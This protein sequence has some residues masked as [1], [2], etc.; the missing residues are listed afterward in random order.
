[1]EQPPQRPWG[2]RPPPPPPQPTPTPQQ[3]PWGYRPPPQPRA[4]RP[5]GAPPPWYRH[6]VGMLLIGAVVV[7][8][9]ALIVPSFTA[10]APEP[11]P[12]VTTANFGTPPTAVP[13]GATTTSAGR[14]ATA[15]D[16]LAQAAQA[17][18]RGAG[19]DVSVTA[20]PG[21]PV[22]VTWEI[23]RA[24]TQGLTENNARLGVMRIMRAF[25]QGELA[26]A[27][28]FREVR[29]V[30]RFQLPGQAVPTP[31]VRLRFTPQTV[32]R[33]EFDDRRYLEAFELADTAAV[34]PAFRG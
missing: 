33:T 6:P 3:R 10:D 32:A 28:G 8:L 18:L 34:H 4:P 5:P 9:G 24:G 26:A 15:A 27:G 12:T 22:T 11:V 30:G 2:Q 7:I 20:R 1:V 14:P 25:Q 17:E 19:E 31:V 13:P 21:G 29:L 23:T 16:R